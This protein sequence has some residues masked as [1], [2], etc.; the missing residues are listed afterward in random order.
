MPHKPTN[1][2]IIKDTAELIPADG[3]RTNYF[4]TFCWIFDSDCSP[5]LA[6]LAVDCTLCKV[7]SISASPSSVPHIELQKL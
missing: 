5:T 3:K 4:F 2:L 7:A 1:C 6:V